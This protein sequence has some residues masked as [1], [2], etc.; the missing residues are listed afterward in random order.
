MLHAGVALE[1][2]KT[3][4]KEAKVKQNTTL[5]KM[6]ISNLKIVKNALNKKYKRL[7]VSVVAQQKQP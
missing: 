6:K 3:K 1:R 7:R 2:Q 4:K 5:M